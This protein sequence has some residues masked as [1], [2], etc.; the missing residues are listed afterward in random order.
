MSKSIPLLAS[1]IPYYTPAESSI[2]SVETALDYLLYQ[3]LSLSLGI[4]PSIAEVGMTVTSVTLNYGIS[5]EPETSLTLTGVP[6]VTKSVLSQSY[7]LD[8]SITSNTSYTL[9]ANDNGYVSTA[10]A[11]VPFL[12]KNYYGASA[13][14]SLNNADVLNLETGD[15]RNTK[16]GNYNFTDLVNT[17]VHIAFPTSYGTPVFRV[18]GLIV[19]F[20]QQTISDF[21][22]ASGGTTSYTIYRSNNLLNG[23]VSISVT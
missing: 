17:Y 18:N 4:S 5:R 16:N 10:T 23:S 21:V 20:T 19:T 22:N 8:V 13:A 3:P 6:L 9:T 11:T 12:F 15:Y 7:V 14:T 1:L 2:Y